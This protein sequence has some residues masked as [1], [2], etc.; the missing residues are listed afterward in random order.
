[1][2]CVVREDDHPVLIG[3]R[4]CQQARQRFDDALGIRIGE[5]AGDEVVEHVG[6]HEGLHPAHLSVGW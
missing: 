6:D 4:V 5:S 1:V 3:A 2:V